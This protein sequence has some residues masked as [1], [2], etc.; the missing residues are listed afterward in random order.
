M[1]YH[2]ALKSSF[3]HRSATLPAGLQYNKLWAQSLQGIMFI[4]LFFSAFDSSRWWGWTLF[5][6]KNLFYVFW[7]REYFSRKA[8]K[9]WLWH[10]M[11]QHFIFFLMLK[12]LLNKGEHLF[13]K[14]SSQKLKINHESKSIFLSFI[15]KKVLSQNNFLSI[16][17]TL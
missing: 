12:L 1:E 15:Q 10:W 16:N 3:Y 14:K 8:R 9:K 11:E 17:N 6:C 7:L 4:K 13:K 2:I 5:L